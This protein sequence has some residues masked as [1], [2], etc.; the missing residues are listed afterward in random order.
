MRVTVSGKAVSRAIR[1]HLLVF[2][3]LNTVL[4]ANA[5]N[6]PLPE[7]PDSDEDSGSDSDS[8]SDMTDYDES[9]IDQEDMPF[10]GS[11][12]SFRSA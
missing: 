6:L 12:S 1:G 8:E 9:T 2:S 5:Y 7:C 4:V 3:V 11:R 10:P